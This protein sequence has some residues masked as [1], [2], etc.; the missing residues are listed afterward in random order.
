MAGY[1]LLNYADD[2]G[3]ARPGIAVGDDVI[4]LQSAVE[5]YEGNGKAAGFLLQVRAR[6]STGQFGRGTGKISNG[7]APRRHP[8]G[9]QLDRPQFRQ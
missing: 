1:K 7:F 9:D 6:Q 5:V 8:R 4:D 3:R 2:N